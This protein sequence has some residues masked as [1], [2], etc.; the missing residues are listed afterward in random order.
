MGYR[1]GTVLA[2][3]RS[4]MGISFGALAARTHASR[5]WVANVESGTRWPSAESWV[6]LADRVLGGNGALV[7]AWE[8]DRAERDQKRRSHALL[9]ATVGEAESV[10]D[11]PEAADLD[12]MNEAVANLA[13]LYLSTPPAPMLEDTATLSRELVQRLRRGACPP[14]ALP[15]LYTALA[16]AEG[17]LAYAALDLGHPDIAG[18]HAAATFKAAA[19]AGHN[20]LMAWARG[21]QS[22][23]AR[24]QKNY[25]IASA[26]VTDGLRY[27]DLR[28]GSE[29]IRLLCGAAQCAANLGD[30]ATAINML[31][32]ADAARN[33][34]DRRPDEVEGLFGF[35]VAKQRYYAGSSLMWLTEESV[36]RR[37]VVEARAAVAIWHDEPIEQRS[38]DDEALAH[39]YEA[40]AQ[41]RLGD[42][43][44]GMSAV[45]PVLDLP[46]ERR[47]SW[48]VKRVVEL[49]ELIKD[50]P[51]GGSAEGTTA[52]DSLLGFA[53]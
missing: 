24:F 51:A 25:D 41:I 2:R 42:I 34:P 26:F 7:T 13:V 50:G 49:A 33:L 23:I 45:Q 52:C 44:A 46:E 5:G 48:M 38:L 18:R 20:N 28:T 35:S 3:L 10:L 43:G 32:Q 14:T 4:D 16:R 9:L 40:T 31:D 37:A 17:V 1:V 22:L 30:T 15:D 27:A 6:R 12:E 19:R 21:T 47:I 29:G 39:V 53:A 8:E 36:L 11:E